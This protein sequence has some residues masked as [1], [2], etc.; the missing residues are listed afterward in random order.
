MKN[1]VYIAAPFFNPEQLKLVQDIEL[2]LR[3]DDIEFFS[4]RLDGTLSEMSGEKKEQA[5]PAIFK[6]NIDNIREH[7]IMIAVLDD[8]DPGTIFEVG[9]FTC[10]KHGDHPAS[11]YQKHFDKI[12]LTLSNHNYGVNVMLRQAVNAH[13]LN[14]MDIRVAIGMILQ[15]NYHHFPMVFAENLSPT[16]STT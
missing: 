4:P 16:E 2:Q 7:N 9:Y 11:N 6:A 15:G 12:L 10:L 13:M 3:M 5:I 14:I 1:S 8:Y